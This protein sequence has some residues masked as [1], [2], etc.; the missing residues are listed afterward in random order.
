MRH[1]LQDTNDL[2]VSDVLSI[3]RDPSPDSSSP[4][5]GQKTFYDYPGKI[6]SCRVG[7]DPLGAVIARR[8]PNGETQYTWNRYSNC[9]YVTNEVSTYTLSDGSA[10]TRTRQ[11]TYDTNTY[12]YAV[13]NPVGGFSQST[14]YTVPDLL[15]TEIGADS[16]PVDQYAGFDLIQATNA[17]INAFWGTNTVVFSYSRVL[18]RYHDENL[19]AL[20]L[21]YDLEQVR[22]FEVMAADPNDQDKDQGLADD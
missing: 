13:S 17:Y 8:L 6:Y 18:P 16:Q 3:E 12:T 7:T 2:Y 15:R 4:I 10:G 5:E 9:G 19:A 21:G 11:W 1:W 22:R 20:D 14:S